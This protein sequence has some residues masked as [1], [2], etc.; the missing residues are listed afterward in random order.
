MDVPKMEVQPIKVRPLLPPQDDLLAVIDSCD[1]RLTEESVVAVTAKVVAIHQG[2][3]ELVPKDEDEVKLVK[4]KLA[5]EDAELYLERDDTVPFPRVFTIYEGTFCSAS[6]IDVSNGNGYF[7]HLPQKSSEFAEVLRQHLQTRYGV[8]E[9]GVVVV[10]SRSYPMRNGTIG[11]SLGYA[12]FRAMYDYRGADD[13]FGKPFHAERINVA[14]CLASTAVIAMGEGSESTPLVVMRDIPHIHFGEEDT[15]DDLYL[16]L[17][18]PMDQ[19]VFAQFYKDK[20]WKKG[21]GH[22]T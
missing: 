15:H 12:G 16:S 2:R 1:L 9:L 13:I 17:K 5:K 7:T 11:M 4:E 20:D 18:V 10:D 3:C 22:T 8:K 6:G 19:D 14:D 21:G